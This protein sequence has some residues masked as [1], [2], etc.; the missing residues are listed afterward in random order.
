ME[1]AREFLEQVRQHHLVKGHLRGLFHALIGRTTTR[2]DGTVLSKGL[3]W[4]ELAELLKD[5]R[6]DRE[7]V[8]ELGLDPNHLPPRDRHRFWYSAIAAAQVDAPE[9]SAQADKL[10]RKT[11]PLGYIIA[12]AKA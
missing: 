6:F 4:R 2:P 11:G 10:A 7:L 5:I 1:G 3:T 9:A 8:R 12:P